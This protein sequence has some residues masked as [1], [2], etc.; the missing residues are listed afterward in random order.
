MSESAI[1]A[2]LVLSVEQ[3]NQKQFYECHDSLEA[4]WME[5]S[6]PEKNFYQGIL[7]VS[8]A[9]YHLGNYNWQGSV[10]LL[11]EGRRRLQK[12]QPAYAG[13]DLDAFVTE[14]TEILL[15]LQQS[16]ADQVEVMAQKVQPPILN[17]ASP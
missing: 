13:L 4:L 1:P 17:L 6:E 15:L 11:G 10:I 9:F 8:V 14:V 7:Q 3:F 12:Y 16:G 5:A 2:E